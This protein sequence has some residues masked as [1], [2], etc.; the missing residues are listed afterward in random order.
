MA[1]VG[2][3]HRLVVEAVGELGVVGHLDGQDLEGDVAGQARLVGEVHHR[4]PTPAGLLDHAVRA[5]FGTGGKARRALAVVALVGP[6]V[7][8]H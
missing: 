7:I 3:P 8:C 1:Q 4:H 6:P 2:D 5:Q